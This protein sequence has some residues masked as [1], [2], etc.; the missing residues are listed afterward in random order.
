MGLAGSELSNFV[1]DQRNLKREK[2]ERS[3]DRTKQ[4]KMSDWKS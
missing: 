2:K 1:K 4:R 3:K